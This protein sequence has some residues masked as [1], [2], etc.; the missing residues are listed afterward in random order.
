MGIEIPVR[1]DHDDGTFHMSTNDWNEEQVKAMLSRSRFKCRFLQLGEGSIAAVRMNWVTFLLATILTWGFAV[2]GLADP[3]TAGYFGA[4]KAWVTQ[5]FTWLYIG[6]QDVWCAFLIYLCFSRF[7]TV[8][9]GQADEKPKYNDFAW[10]AMLFTCGVAVGLY[11]FGVGEPLYFYRQPTL[12]SSWEYDYTITKTAVTNDAQR[13]QQAIFQTVYHWGIH[14]WVPYCLLGILIGIVA[15]RWHMPMA[16]RSCFYPLIGDHALGLCGDF[17]DALSIAT[18]T[19]GVCTSLGLGVSQISGGL[20][21][22]ADLSCIPKDNCIAAGGTWDINT[23]GANSCFGATSDIKDCTL[24]HLADEGAKSGSYVVIIIL[25]TLS[26]TLS[27]ISGVDNGIKFF[28]GLAFTCGMCV[29]LPILYADNTWYILNVLV[30]SVG[31]YLQ[32][33]IQVGFDCEAF[34]Q[35]GFEMTSGNKYWGSDGAASISGVL[36]KAGFDAAALDK[37]GP[38]CG[39]QPN[40]CT[41][42]II[43]AGQAAAIYWASTSSATYA[44]KS[45]GASVTNT[46]KAFRMS[47]KSIEDAGKVYKKMMEV[48][49]GIGMGVP[50]GSGWATDTFDDLTGAATGRT[51]GTAMCGTAACTDLW[52]MSFPRCPETVITD[53]PRWGTCD[54]YLLNCDTFR[55]YY[56][57]TN[58]MYMD[59]W[60]IFYWAWWITWAPFVGFFIAIISRGRTV[61]EVILGAFFCP[62]LFAFFW[63]SIMGGLAIKMQRV[64]EVALQVRPD[65]GHATAT[66]A[67][68]YAYGGVPITPQ[69]K[70]LFEQGYKMISCVLPMDKQIYELMYPYQGFLGFIW[71]FLW[72]GLVIYFLTSSDSGSLVDDI[73]S[74]SGLSPNRIPIWQKIYW[75]WTE[76]LVAISLLTGGGSSVLKAIRSVSIIFGL[77]YT[78]I[79]CFMVPAL[80]R[81]LKHCLNEQDI[82]TSFKF[83]TQLL[84]FFELFAPP[85]GS[86]FTP[87]EHIKHWLIGLFC[88][89]LGVYASLRY[90]SPTS[91]KF[92]IAAGLFVQIMFSL[93]FVFQIVEAGVKGFHTL[94]WVAF[95]FMAFI[96]SVARTDAR[97]K[98]KIW[99]NPLEDFFIALA[100]YP[101]AVAQVHMHAASEGKDKPLY[102]ASTTE[103]L[104]QMKSAMSE[105]GATS[106]TGM[107]EVQTADA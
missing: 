106:S 24:A 15:F 56:D 21:Y 63:F 86:P 72:F 69:S 53:A 84:D 33:I 68:H 27:V 45:Y 29:C 8:K 67:E 55:T 28:A 101:I 89:G 79:L 46:L 102:F 88:P 52:S 37:T 12:W 40:P 78:F 13:A 76:G 95:T 105:A 48:Y 10:F 18:T 64:A 62:T 70:M 107:K 98:D 43:G 104:D 7:A 93:F 5:N 1:V 32:Y 99:G 9:L 81:A 85:A 35:L 26:A 71:F 47:S 61:R 41:M 57:D 74:A 3:N 103:M 100:A 49:G 75:C 66:C 60:T 91:P 36:T 65:V 54:S 82:M 92:G 80:Y 73:I 31:Y 77:P 59:W 6:T 30:Q 50:C 23:Y 58:P 19:F 97:L 2:W 17:I 38:D 22:L 44:Q 16:I 25:I 83:N 96:I 39:N 90:S 34:Q 87:S 42:G 94:G 4:G 51:A 20:Q 14:G 11:V